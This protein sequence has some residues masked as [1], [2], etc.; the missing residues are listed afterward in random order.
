MIDFIPNRP[1]YFYQKD[2]IG[3]HHLRNLSWRCLVFFDLSKSKLFQGSICQAIDVF[4][5][6]GVYTDTLYTL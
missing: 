3:I 1:L 6:Y 5:I 2:I 4:C